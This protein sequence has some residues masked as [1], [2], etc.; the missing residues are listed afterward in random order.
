MLAAE[1]LEASEAFVENVECGAVA[2]TDAVVATESD[3]RNGGHLVAREQ[4]IAEI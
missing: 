2:E 4:F 3:A 1:L